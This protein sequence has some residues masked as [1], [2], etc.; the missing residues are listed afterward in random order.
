MVQDPNT[1]LLYSFGPFVLDPVRRVLRRNDAVVSLRPKTLEVLLV[2]VEHRGELLPKEKLL[3]LVW[4]D[5]I[6]E[7]NNLARHIST[8]RRVFADQA[9][10]GEYII[11]VPLRGY[12][13]VAPVS[14]SEARLQITV[15]SKVEEAPAS[16][17]AAEAATGRSRSSTLTW[18][19]LVS[20]LV[21]IASLA[22]TQARRPRAGERGGV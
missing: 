17:V 18:F 4:P 15:P 14:V 3:E 11:T 9:A 10:G 7:E 13:F 5:T 12:R 16:L 20:S 8:L 6:V 19:G 1:D 2:L 21:I 22:G